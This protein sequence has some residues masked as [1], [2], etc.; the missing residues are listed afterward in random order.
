[1][2]LPSIHRRNALPLGDLAEI[3]GPAT[4]TSVVRL[5]LAAALAGTL[6]VSVLAARSAGTGRAAV[7]PEGAST[8][9]VALDMSASIAG[10]I[11]ARVATT[12]KGIVAANQGIGL[13]MFSDTAYEL[14]PPNSP[15][16]ALS[17]FI[18]FF[19]PTTYAHGNPI[20]AQ[21]PWSEFSGGTRIS[22]GLVTAQRR[23]AQGRR[24]ARLDPHRQRPRRR[25]RRP[26]CA[27][28][29]GGGAQ[30]GA[31]PGPDRAAVRRPDG[32]APLRR[33]V[34]QRHL[35]RPERLHP[36]RETAPAA[37]RRLG[38]VGAARPRDPARPPARRQRAPERPLRDRSARHEAAAP[39]LG[40][41]RRR[42]LRGGR[43][44]ARAPR[45]RRPRVADVADPGRPPLPRD[46]LAPVAVAAADDPAG[47]PGATPPRP[48]RRR[49]VSP[50]GSALLVQ[51]GR[52]RPGDA[53]GPADDEGA[54]GGEPP[55]HRRHLRRDVRALGRGE[56]ARRDRRH[57][58]AD[59]RS[60]GAGAGGAPRGVVLPGGDHDSTRRTTT[61]SRTSSSRCCCAIPATRRSAATHAAA[62]ATAAATAWARSEPATDV[63]RLVPDAASGRCSRW[64]R[65]YR[66]SLSP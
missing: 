62:T 47:R 17:Q 26:G 29:G 8:G 37:D 48:R 30:G 1:M 57:E 18:P 4:R 35:R 64:R 32:Q 20:F 52:R 28:A 31:H 7:L 5:V 49:R 23:A 16:A 55:A 15:P 61:R 6:A 24:H 33:A 50:R 14:L 21:S 44:A 39:A 54:G 66:S 13:V 22:A 12:L 3:E 38:A 63:R 2:R 45:A 59:Q 25:D 60:D 53:S 42:R 46:A 27:R 40:P 58:P 10:P 56:P 11:Y 65:R 51:P 43:R 36:L 34:R 19:V 9:V 41:D